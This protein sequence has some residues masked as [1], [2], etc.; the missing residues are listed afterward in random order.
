MGQQETMCLNVRYKIYNKKYLSNKVYL[1][2]QSKQF[3]NQKA[4]SNL[5]ARQGTA[6]LVS[7]FV[8][9]RVNWLTRSVF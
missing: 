2:R 5:G 8:I 3:Q 4:W 9:E 7:T 6:V 1:G